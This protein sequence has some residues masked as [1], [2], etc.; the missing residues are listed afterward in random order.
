MNGGRHRGSFD[1]D[2]CFT[3]IGWLLKLPEDIACRLVERIG[4]KRAGRLLDGI[5][6][7]GY[8]A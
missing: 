2:G 5:E 1:F 4:K 8:P 6:H 3:M 7:N